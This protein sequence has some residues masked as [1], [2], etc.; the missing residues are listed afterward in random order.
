MNARHSSSG[1][2]LSTPR[3]ETALDGRGSSAGTAPERPGPRIIKRYVN[4]KLYDTVE[5]RYVTLDEIAHLI[6]TGTEVTI[7]DDRSNRD[8]TSIT[9]VQIIF[10]AEKRYSRMNMRLLCDLIRNG[11]GQPPPRESTPQP[12]ALQSTEGIQ[13][14]L[15]QSMDVV[16]E[17]GRQLTDRAQE[18]VASSQEAVVQLQRKMNERLGS[19]FEVVATVGKLKR[20]LGRIAG[21]IEDLRE[22]LRGLREPAPL[23]LDRARP[24]SRLPRRLSNQHAA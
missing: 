20:E 5:S 10:E 6:R 7:L 4:R 1:A 13:Q 15:G 22:R 12:E 9:L 21:R 24:D 19:A 23:E 14:V 17:R 18:M 16:L 3:G 8:L 11:G 2:G